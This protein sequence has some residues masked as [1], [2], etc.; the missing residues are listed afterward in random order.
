MYLSTY[1]Y[2]NQ[3]L[4]P[5]CYPVPLHQCI[6]FICVLLNFTQYLCATCVSLNL[7]STCVCLTIFPFHFTVMINSLGNK[8]LKP[9][10]AVFQ[11][12]MIMFGP[13]PAMIGVSWWQYFSCYFLCFILNNSGRKILCYFW[14]NFLW[15]FDYTSCD[16]N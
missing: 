9:A 10:T 1:L 2:N 3:Y 6:F 8:V 12:L 4:S 11:Y 15:S 14:Y 16:G 5:H 7:S 13:G